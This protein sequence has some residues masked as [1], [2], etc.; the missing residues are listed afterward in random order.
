MI[1]DIDRL[2]V[3]KSCDD[4]TTDDELQTWFYLGQ[5]GQNIYARS[6]RS[7]LFFHA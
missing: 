6:V 7:V 4:K 3:G 2:G 5:V 1:S